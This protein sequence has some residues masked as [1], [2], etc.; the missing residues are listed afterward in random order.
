MTV[1]GR[2][3]NGVVVFDAGQMLPDGTLVVVSP[4]QPRAQSPHGKQRVEVPLVHSAN[5]G[6]LNLTGDQI[7]EILEQ[8]DVSA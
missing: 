4:L 7:A 5:P 1:Q 2:V 8:E 6:T 3:Q